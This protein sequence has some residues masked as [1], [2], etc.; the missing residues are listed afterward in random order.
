MP[1]NPNI[2]YADLTYR[3]IGAAIRVHN[4]LGPGMKEAHYQRA[5][6]V[7]MQQDGMQVDEEYVMEIYDGDTWLGRMYL[8][9]WVEGK[10]IVEDKALS[11]LLTNLEVAQV[12]SYL[13]A[14]NA[15][16]GLLINFGRKRLEYKRILPP[17]KLTDWKE[18]IQKFLWKPPDQK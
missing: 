3:I 6:T 8:D 17:Q 16:V 9:H 7:E 18:H 14:M 1:L 11:H 4:R 10:I 12:I 13:A 5:L 15:P 2:P